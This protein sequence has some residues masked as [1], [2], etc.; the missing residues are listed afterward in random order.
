VLQALL[1]AEDIVMWT[2]ARP[3]VVDIWWP[4]G[5]SLDWEHEYGT[6]W[7][8]EALS[9]ERRNHSTLSNDQPHLWTNGS[10]SCFTS[11]CKRIS[12]MPLQMLL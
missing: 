12:A 9:N 4:G 7:Q 2:V 5:C 1:N 6:W 11:N 3:E 8:Q 10:R